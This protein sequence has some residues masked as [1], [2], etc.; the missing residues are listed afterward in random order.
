MTGT[1]TSH[2]EKY[3]WIKKQNKTRG[4]YILRAW[5]KLHMHQIM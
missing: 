1:G 3:Q 4:T 2:A 5:G